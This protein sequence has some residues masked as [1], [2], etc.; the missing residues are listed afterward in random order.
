MLILRGST[1]FLSWCFHTYVSKSES[2]KEP[3]N[4]IMKTK[5]ECFRTVRWSA[6]CVP[7]LDLINGGCKIVYSVRIKNVAVINGV[8]N[9]L[10]IIQFNSER[11]VRLK[12]IAHRYEFKYTESNLLSILPFHYYT[13]C[14]QKYN[15]IIW[16]FSRITYINTFCTIPYAQFL[17]VKFTLHAYDIWLKARLRHYTGNK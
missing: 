10:L 16:M 17:Y 7:S 15:Y 14:N 5:L 3:K 11:G 12:L 8:I 6:F 9:M 13:V 4:C 1:K 2:I